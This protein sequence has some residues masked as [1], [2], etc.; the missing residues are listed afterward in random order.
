VGNLP[1]STND[2]SLNDL[3]TSF[4]QVNSATIITD[5]FSGR[6]RGFGF[7]EMENDEEAEKAISEMNGKDIDGRQIVVNEAR[8]R[9]E[10][11]DNGGRNR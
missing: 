1:Y 7:V 5:K 11:S 4:G 9:E 2:Q 3:F 10:R 6:S 8:P